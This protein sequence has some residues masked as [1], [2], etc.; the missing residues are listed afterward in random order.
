VTA[1]G[2]GTQGLNDAGQ[3]A[4]YFALADGRSGIAVASPI[5]EP[6]SA[7][8]LAAVGGTLLLRRRRVC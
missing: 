6:S 5:P 4:F 8:L 3:L 2:F 7:L 1:V